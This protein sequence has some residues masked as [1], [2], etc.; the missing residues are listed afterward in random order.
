MAKGLDLASA[1]H[2]VIRGH[3]DYLLDRAQLSE[4]EKTQVLQKIVPFVNE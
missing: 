2:L 4:D 3:I 1:Q